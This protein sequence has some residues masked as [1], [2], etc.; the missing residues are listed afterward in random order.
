MEFS[1]EWDT[2]PR[3]KELGIKKKNIKLPRTFQS[4]TREL[5]YFPGREDSYVASTAGGAKGANL[6]VGVKDGGGRRRKGSGIGEGAR[7]LNAR[8]WSMKVRDWK[9]F[10]LLFL[11]C[12]A[13][14]R[15]LRSSFARIHVNQQIETFSLIVS[16]VR[17]F[18]NFSVLFR[19]ANICIRQNYS[20]LYSTIPSILIKIQFHCDVIMLSNATLAVI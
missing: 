15:V 20:I 3:N 8:T 1:E 9:Y 7:W 11:H 14:S 12:R 13:R 6:C 16:I 2:W 4:R 10:A 18:C 19:H 17:S 5:C